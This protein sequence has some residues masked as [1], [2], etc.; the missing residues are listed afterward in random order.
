[1]CSEPRYVLIVLAATFSNVKKSR[2]HFYTM[3]LGPQLQVQWRTPESAR[4]MGHRG[5]RIEVQEL[6]ETGGW[7]TAY[8]IYH[9]QE[10]LETVAHGGISDNDAL[11]MF[12]M[13]GAQLYQDR[14]SDCW[15][16]LGPL[17]LGRPCY[18]W[19]HTSLL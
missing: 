19:S 7:I 9:G 15:V 18:D 14:E 16:Y 5:R 2:Q 1:M 12:S 13:D 3:L 17:I 4:N 8:D 10:Y 6:D 11:L